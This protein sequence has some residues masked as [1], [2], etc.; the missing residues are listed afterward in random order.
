M[1]ACRPVSACQEVVVERDVAVNLIE[2][3]CQP[4]SSEAVQHPKTAQR[5]KA[6]IVRSTTCHHSGTKGGSYCSRGHDHQL[7]TQM[8]IL[9]CQSV[10]PHEVLDK[11]R[12]VKW[13][14]LNTIQ[15]VALPASPNNLLRRSKEGAT[16][17]DLDASKGPRLAS[18]QWRAC[19]GQSR[20]PTTSFDRRNG[21]LSAGKRASSCAAGS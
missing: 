12:R 16:N 13:N 17:C 21:R 5:R 8:R 4:G 6:M 9:R 15:C 1:A 18:S 14:A 11:S 10:Y 2:R 20:T 3:G 19:T 7:A